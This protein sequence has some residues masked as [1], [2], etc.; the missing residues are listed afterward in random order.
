MVDVICDT[1]FLIHIANNRIRNL[2]TLD[3]EIGSIRFVVPDTVISELQGLLGDSAKKD[4]A[5]NALEHAGRLS[6]AKFGA[7]PTDDLLVS[8]VR[9]RGGI[10]A[11]MDRELKSRIKKAGGSVLSVSSNRIVLE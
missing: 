5:S 9:E 6:T 4:A 7:G 8:R 2:A 1:S 11:T 3:T 10:V